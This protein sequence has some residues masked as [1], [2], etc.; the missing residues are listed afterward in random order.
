MRSRRASL[1][2]SVALE[3]PIS[4]L[5]TTPLIDVL[6]VLLIMFIVTIPI[7][8]H[9]VRVDLPAPGSPAAPPVSHRLDIDSAGR[10]GWD[11]APLAAAALPG[12]LSA[13]RA[14]NPDGLLLLRTDGETRYE[15]FDRL[16]AVVKRSGIAR[17]AFLGNERFAGTAI[18]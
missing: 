14:A 6:L 4:D 10:I 18:R 7:A 5:N 17:L 11:G 13:F 15:D 2:C 1:S 8:T 3:T 9:K 12:R 16:L